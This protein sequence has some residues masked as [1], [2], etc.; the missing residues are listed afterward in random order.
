MTRHRAFPLLLA[1]IAALAL[2]SAASAART[3]VAVGIGDQNSAMFT[4]PLYKS[5]KLKKTRYF[6]DWNAISKPGELAQADQFVA[7]ARAANVKVLM[8]ISTDDLTPGRG[9]LPTRSQYKAF[10]GELIKR[11]RPLGVREWGVWN[12][13]NHNTQPTT[14]NPARAALFYRDMRKLCKGCTIVAL[15]V[16]D[17]AGVERYIAR[18]LKAAGSVGRSA[19]IFGIHNYS[20]V[21]RKLRKGSNRYPGTGRVI[22]AFRKKNKR[23]K[24]W[25]T[26]TGGLAEFGKSFPCSLKRQADTTKYMFTL[27][28]KNR[29]NVTRLY[30]YN[31]TGADCLPRFDAGLVNADGTARPAYRTFKT[32]LRS[33]NR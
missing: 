11:Y 22:K 29:R 2:P 30:S 3:N 27:A 16:L 17:Q 9:T 18:W 25:Y 6:I 4:S 24:F 26:E 12:E 14:K 19:T 5:L 23:A 15:D 20:E 28:R 21:N 10:V 13:A 33:F 32:Q 8:H 1:L 31:W 7:A